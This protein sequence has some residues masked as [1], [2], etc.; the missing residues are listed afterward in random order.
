MKDW[1]P[2]EN[3]FHGLTLYC[4]W[5]YIKIAIKIHY[6]TI[7]LLF[8]TFVRYNKDFCFIKRSKALTSM[9][10]GAKLTL[11]MRYNVRI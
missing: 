5:C 3:S 8:E 4:T 11:R 2:L 7:I 10:S 6:K 1:E 9:I